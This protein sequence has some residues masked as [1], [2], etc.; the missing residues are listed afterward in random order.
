MKVYTVFGEEGEYSGRTTWAIASYFDEELARRH[1]VLAT[2][3]AN[4]I[5]GLYNNLYKRS[6]R[7]GGGLSP[8]E[9][10]ESRRLERSNPYDPEG[11]TWL[12]K[13]T[14][15]YETTEVL[16]TLKEEL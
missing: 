1:V 15:Y 5:Y 11:Q 13:V 16:D 4:E 3:K 14:Y 10:K 12:D 2:E 7:E 9:I 8:E 6:L